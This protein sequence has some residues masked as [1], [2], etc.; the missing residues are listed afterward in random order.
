MLKNELHVKKPA[1]VNEHYKF[2]QEEWCDSIQPEFF[3]KLVDGY[4]HLAK[5]QLAKGCLTK[6]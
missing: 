5:E 1:K 4:K 3:Q 6:Y 2:C